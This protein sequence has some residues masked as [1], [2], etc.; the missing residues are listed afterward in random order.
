M[1]AGRWFRHGRALRYS[2]WRGWAGSHRTAPFANTL[3]ISGTCR[4]MEAC[5]K[6][7]LSA[8]QRAERKCGPLRPRKLGENSLGGELHIRCSGANLG[9]DLGFELG[10]ILL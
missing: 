5:R 1:P 10:E 6:R 2:T 4:C 8:A 9:I 7:P 3:R